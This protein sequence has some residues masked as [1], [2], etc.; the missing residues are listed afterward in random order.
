MTPVILCIEDEPI[1]RKTIVEELTDAGY[2]T[3]E[4]SNGVEGL[5]AISEHKPN[6]IICDVQMPVMDGNDMLIS[7]RENHPEFDSIPFL[8]LSGKN[9]R[10]N[11]IEGRLRGA[12]DYLIKPVDY[13]LLLA[14]VESR[15]MSA[16]RF[17]ESKQIELDE[18]RTSILG[19]LPHELRTPLNHILGF[20][21]MIK[22]ETFGPIGNEKYLEYANF[23]HSSG[24]TLMSIINNVLYLTD[25]TSG[26]LEVTLN[27]CNIS[28]AIS[29]CLRK[30]S[31]ISMDH[32]IRVTLT[33]E[34]D[35]PTVTAANEMLENILSPLLSNAFKFTPDGGSITVRAFTDKA[36]TVT[37]VISDTG[38]GIKEE[39][40]S[41][42][43]KA[44]GRV[45]CDMTR[46]TDGPGIGLTLARALMEVLGGEFDL[47]SELGK[48]TTI[49][50]RFNVPE[51]TDILH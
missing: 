33:L 49:T 45:E 17:E 5:A 14:T 43:M 10:E 20:S 15:L 28:T 44:F 6:M 30:Y 2:M 23:I 1:L 35:L 29:N 31:D 47:Q 21:S 46:S 34:S 38:I 11:I 41:K 22:D 7:L 36:H 24:E 48:G 26:N 18:L 51:R 50:L 3:I 12:D 27:Q 40:I 19:L 13:T 37:V 4:A 16:T 42:V 9:E 39:D 25:I 32:D 8:F